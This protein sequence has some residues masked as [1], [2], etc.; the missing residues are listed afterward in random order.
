MRE[1]FPTLQ[2][3]VTERAFSVIAKTQLSS[4]PG[5]CPPRALSRSAATQ[6]HVLRQ[7]R[8]LADQEMSTIRLFR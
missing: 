1:T 5:S 3:Y 7:L 8:W 2:L 4:N 6:L